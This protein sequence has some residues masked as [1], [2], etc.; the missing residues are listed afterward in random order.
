M[1]IQAVTTKNVS[2]RTTGNI[3]VHSTADSLRPEITG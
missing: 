3:N 2:H 1:S